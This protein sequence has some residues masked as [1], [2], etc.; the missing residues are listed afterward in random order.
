MQRDIRPILNV[1]GKVFFALLCS[2]FAYAVTPQ[3]DLSALFY[4]ANSMRSHPS[5]PEVV[6]CLTVI[7]VDY[8]DYAGKPQTGQLVVNKDAAEDMKSA[9]TFMK[10]IHYP[11]NKVKPVNFYDWQDS[12]SMNDDNTSSYNF[13]YIANSNPKRPVLSNH[14][15]GLAVDLNPRCNPDITDSQWDPPSARGYRPQNANCKF[16]SVLGKQVKG[17]FKDTLHWIWGGDWKSHQDAQHFEKPNHAGKGQYCN[18]R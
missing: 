5:L 9:F 14:A 8:F 4:P 13:R 17:Y 3:S 2:S 15:F 1:I 7:D 12:A 16:S 10:S 18:Q 11:I 6:K